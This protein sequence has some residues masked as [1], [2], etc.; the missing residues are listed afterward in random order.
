MSVEAA[1]AFS[2]FLL[3]LGLFFTFYREQ[4]AALKAQKALDE[5]GGAV[6][7]W[8][9][10]VAFAERYTGTEYSLLNSATPKIWSK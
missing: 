3:I 10:A 6:A 1:L 2:L 7:E 8:S 5:I 9:Y 4:S